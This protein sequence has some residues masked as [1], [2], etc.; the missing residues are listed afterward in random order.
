MFPCCWTGANKYKKF[1]DRNEIWQ[2]FETHG[3]DFL[4]LNNYSAGQV[5]E[6][7]WFSEQLEK[8]WNTDPLKVCSKQCL[9]KLQEHEDL[10]YANT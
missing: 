8:S 9:E 5:F 6:H 7:I 4:N 1:Q 2:L 3:K 10:Q